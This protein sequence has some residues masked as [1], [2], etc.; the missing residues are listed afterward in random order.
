MPHRQPWEILAHMENSAGQ[1]YADLRA[2]WDLAHEVAA[3]YL[4]GSTN[5]AALK[6]S[7][8]QLT[9]E[10]DR[11]FAAITTSARRDPMRVVFTGSEMPYQDAEE[12][13]E[14]VRRKRLL[15]VTVA[16]VDCDRFHPMMDWTTGGA[17]DRLRAVHDIVGHCYLNLG[18]DRHSEYATWR[19]Q[20]QLH[21]GLARQA[22]ALELHAKHSVRW[23]TGESANHKAVL[24]DTRLIDRS[25][26]AGGQPENSLL[27]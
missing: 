27:A 26:L 21:S 23:T 1:A 2:D 25:R 10:V 20:E 5:P 24:I 9:L 8:E 3:A 11:L 18:F 15:E 14:S 19:F 4:N 6:A 13:I 22:L 12:L 16:A 7:Y 17:Y